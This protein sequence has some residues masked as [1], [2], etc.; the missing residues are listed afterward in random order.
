MSVVSVRSRRVARRKVGVAAAI[1]LL[2]VV[3]TLFVALPAG[4][5]GDIHVFTGPPG[6]HKFFDFGRPGLRI[7]DRLVARGALLNET[8]ESEV[9]SFSMDCVVIR[10]ITDDPSGP[11]GVYR[12][13]YLL[14]L[15]EGDLILEGLD[16]HGPGTHTFAVLGGTEAYAS[17]RG[18]ALLLDGANGSE[19]VINLI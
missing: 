5:H 12:C 7:G 3:A 13:S 6:T 14:Q 1:A 17:A 4:A 18:D 15:A 9:G 11:G 10:A 19:L 8:Q 2:L 16:P